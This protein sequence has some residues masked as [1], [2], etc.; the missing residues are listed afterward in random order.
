MYCGPSNTSVDVVLGKH[1]AY[2]RQC[3]QCRGVGSMDA[4]GAWAPINISSCI[5]NGC[6]HTVLYITEK[7]DIL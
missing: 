7:I 3:I 2:S 5:T 1:V 4:M 6:Q